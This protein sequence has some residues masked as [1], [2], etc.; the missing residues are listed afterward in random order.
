MEF[1]KP[2]ITADLLRRSGLR[3]NRRRQ[4]QGFANRE[5][6][7]IVFPCPYSWRFLRLLQRL[8][9]SR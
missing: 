1:A 7:P 6:E 2:Q 8:H 4:A 9:E 3:I 5:R